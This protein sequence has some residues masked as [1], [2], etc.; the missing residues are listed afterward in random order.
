MDP[1][2]DHIPCFYSVWVRG[3]KRLVDK[4]GV[5]KTPGCRR[6]KNIQPARSNDRDT[7]GDFTWIDEVNAHSVC[8]SFGGLHVPTHNL[9][10]KTGSFCH[11]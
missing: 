7:E 10:H 3:L 5:A 4:A 2:A 11:V 9:R 6:R 1:N 8:F